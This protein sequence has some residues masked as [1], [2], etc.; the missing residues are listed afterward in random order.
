[1]FRLDDLCR[2]D[3]LADDQPGNAGGYKPVDIRDG[4]FH[5]QPPVIDTAGQCNFGASRSDPLRGTFVLVQT[6]LSVGAGEVIEGRFH[7]KSLNRN[8]DSVN[9]ISKSRARLR[10]AAPVT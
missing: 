1:M 2:N 9:P 10:P 3:R 5:L 8:R 7:P 4:G 6:R